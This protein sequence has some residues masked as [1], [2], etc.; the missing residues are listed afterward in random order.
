MSR[1]LSEEMVLSAR[2]TTSRFPTFPFSLVP[3][4]YGGHLWRLLDL[5]R[6]WESVQILWWAHPTL[7]YPQ[8]TSPC[9]GNT[10]QLLPYIPRPSG[11]YAQPLIYPIGSDSRKENHVVQTESSFPLGRHQ[12]P[13]FQNPPTTG[14]HLCLA[15]ALNFPRSCTQKP[16]SQT[17]FSTDSSISGVRHL[18]PM[19]TPHQ[20]SITTT[21]TRRLTRSHLGT[22][23]GSRILPIIKVFAHTMHRH[24]SG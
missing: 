19:A 3:P 11:W 13:H 5:H 21:F 23:P 2:V 9:W 10:K 15:S 20:F 17:T 1:G 16:P 22:C 14:R 8:M 4:H 18:S 24:R 6:V 12:L 7:I